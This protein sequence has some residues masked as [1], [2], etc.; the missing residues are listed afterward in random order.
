MRLAL[1]TLLCL[2]ALSPAAAQTAPVQ[3]YVPAPWWMDKPIVA[4]TGHVWTEVPANRASVSATYDAVDRD[5]ADAQR[6]A[7]EKIRA[8][9]AALTAYGAD[10][11]RVETSFRIQ[12]LYEQYKDKQGEVNTNARA[13]KIERYQVSANVAVE[14]RDVR[15]AERVY[16]T[17]LAAKPSSTRPVSFRLEPD[18]ETRTQMSKLAVEDAR[19]RALLATE[20]AG[21]KLGPVRV[22]DPTARACD[23]DVLIVGAPRTYADVDA[24]RVPPLPVPPVASRMAPPPPPPPPPPA[25][26]GRGQAA[27][28]GIQLPIQ[29]PLQRLEARACVVYGLI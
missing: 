14:L 20:A 1:A 23:T 22:I 24:Y 26:E 25:F 21:A 5:A 12:P 19:R 28:E 7:V 10:K 9:A 27:V 2:G 11:V 13:D 29:P 18:N 17:L 8:L 4:S 3:T 6:Q 16:A 15:L